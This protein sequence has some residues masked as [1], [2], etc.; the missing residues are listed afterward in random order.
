MDSTWSTR[1]TRSGNILQA[2]Y[3]ETTTACGGW[4]TGDWMSQYG[5]RDQANAGKT[6]QASLH[7]YYSDMVIS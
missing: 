3:C 5:S 4:V 6:Y 1:M 7:Y 2:H